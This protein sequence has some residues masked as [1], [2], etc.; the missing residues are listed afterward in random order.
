MQ[1]LREYWAH[2]EF[3]PHIV[4]D[5][6]AKSELLETLSQSCFGQYESSSSGL[7]SPLTLAPV[8]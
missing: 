8:R 5:Q 2:V 4:L 1:L 3:F 6:N 7:D